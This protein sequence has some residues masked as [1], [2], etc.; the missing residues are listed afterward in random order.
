MLWWSIFMDATMVCN[1]FLI[2]ASVFFFPQLRYKS[3]LM[4]MKG[5]GWLALSS[6]QIES[7]KKAG[8]LISEVSLTWLYHKH[9]L[10][11]ISS[12]RGNLQMDWRAWRAHGAGLPISF[13]GYLRSNPKTE[14]DLA[15]SE[16]TCWRVKGLFQSL[17]DDQQMFYVQLWSNLTHY[18]HGDKERICHPSPEFTQFNV[19]GLPDFRGC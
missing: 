11:F 16:F 4:G 18:F 1:P 3:D 6:P 15:P 12:W 14:Q 19:L 17:E 8:E 9:T 10:A 2:K 13:W 5:T 7:A